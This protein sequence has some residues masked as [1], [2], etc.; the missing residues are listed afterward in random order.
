[1][2]NAN[3]NAQWGVVPLTTSC[4][5]KNAMTRKKTCYDTILKARSVARATSSFPSCFNR[6]WVQ[7]RLKRKKFFGIRKL[8][9]DIPPGH[10]LVKNL[11][12]GLFGHQADNYH[13]D[14][15]NDKCIKGKMHG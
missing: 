13:C 15:S 4:Y 1:M 3:L 6:V 8:F 9:P 10:C 5:A 11:F 12:S 14:D 2:F 7:H